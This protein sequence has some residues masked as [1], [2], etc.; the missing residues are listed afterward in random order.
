V[1]DRTKTMLKK[2]I[3]TKTSATNILASKIMFD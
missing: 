2:L 3:A 1:R